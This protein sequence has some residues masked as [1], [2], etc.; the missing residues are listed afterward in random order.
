MCAARGTG[1][2]RAEGKVR[3]HAPP[4][5]LTVNFASFKAVKRHSKSLSNEK[6]L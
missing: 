5:S 2:S 3:E 1:D 6:N 4:V